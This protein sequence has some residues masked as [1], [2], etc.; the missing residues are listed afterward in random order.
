MKKEPRKSTPLEIGHAPR[1]I[2]LTGGIALPTLVIIFAVLAALGGGTYYAV[3]KQQAP[4]ETKVKGD[5]VT[6]QDGSMMKEPETAGGDKMTEEDV[7]MEEVDAMLSDDLMMDD[8]KEIEGIMDGETGYTGALLAGSLRASPLLDFTKADY[9]KAIASDRLVVLYFYANWCPICKAEF[10]KTQAA[11]NQLQGDDVVGFRVNFNDDQTDAN[12]ITL[13][14]Q[15]G[16]AY[17][18][19]KVFVKNGMRVLKAP[20]SWETLHYVSEIAKYK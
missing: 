4:E 11:F 19:T 2:F 8:L 13:A 10:P 15:Y 6:K 5:L 1:P 14:K 3:T 12:E 18:H 17:Q 16:V 20:D 7:M 9:D